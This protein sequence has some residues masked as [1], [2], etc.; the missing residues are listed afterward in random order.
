MPFRVHYE[1][2]P[3]DSPIFY[4]LELRSPSDVRGKTDENGKAVIKLA[5]YAWSTLLDVK[6]TNRHYFATFVLSKEVIRK[7]GPVEQLRSTL[8]HKSWG[9]GYPELKLEVQP[10][11]RP[12]RNAR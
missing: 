1:S 10:V 12:N 5:D 7:G 8:R 9:E 3:A 4:H 11:K 6:D 2:Y